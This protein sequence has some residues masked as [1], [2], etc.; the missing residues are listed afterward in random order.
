VKFQAPAPAPAGVFVFGP[1]VDPAR[2]RFQ[3]RRVKPSPALPLLLATAA[4]AGCGQTSPGVVSPLVGEWAPPGSSCESAGGVAYDKTGEWAGYDVVGT[5]KLNGNRLT[6]RVTERGGYDQ[7]ARKVSGEKPS[8]ATV[9]SLSQSDLV[10][11]LPDGS[12]QRLQRC[13]R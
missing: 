4:L 9:V 12:T 8:T 11:R 10:L 5:W 1:D 13:K 7:P 3:N 2:R 6:T